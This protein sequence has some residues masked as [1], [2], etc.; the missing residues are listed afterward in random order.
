MQAGYFKTAWNDVKSSGGWF[1]K[2]L[3]LA[4]ICFIPIFGAIVV[5]G[6]LFGWARD[7]AWGIRGPL[8]KHIFG[9]EDGKL[10]SRGFFVLVIGI[11]FA[12]LPW[13]IELVWSFIMGF[14]AVTLGYGG[15][16]YGG[17]SVFGGLLTLV[18]S[19]LTIAASFV[20]MLF[21]WVGS[22][23]MS[24]YGR[25]SAGFQFTKLWAMMRHDFGGLMRIFGMS[26]LLSVIFAIIFYVIAFIVVF[27]IVFA[28]IAATGGNM[29]AEYIDGNV[30]GW[31][32]AFGGIAFVVMFVVGYVAVAA[33][34]WI[35]ML[36]VRALGY[37]TRQ[38]DVPAWRGQDDP[39]P[40]EMQAAAARQPHQQPPT[41]PQPYGQPYQQQ[42]HAPYGQAPQ[43]GPAPYGQ[44]PQQGVGTA[45]QPGYPQPGAQ[46]VA[47]VQDGAGA[48]GST[49]FTPAPAPRSGEQNPVDLPVTDDSSQ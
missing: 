20:A 42:R 23:R 4:L 12:L 2:V 9:N 41:G 26:I 35:Q 47:G 25:L 18:F 11:V 3:L 37:W 43:P 7:I 30:I 13:V 39:M 45:P 8:P 24:V 27:L 16:H 31:I 29:R 33:G 48:P 10:Y 32:L 15:G 19:V 28:G 46:P 21:Q 36:V 40:F 1:G 6:Y 17:M 44:A 14:G 49:V 38:F 5:S 22:M 34:V